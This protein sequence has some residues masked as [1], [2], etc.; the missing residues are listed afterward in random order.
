MKKDSKET[1]D[2]RECPDGA[3]VHWSHLNRDCLA[4]AFG[5]LDGGVLALLVLDRPVAFVRPTGRQGQH[6]VRVGCR[7]GE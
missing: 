2:H 7:N 6:V 1:R 4:N 3:T 5:Q